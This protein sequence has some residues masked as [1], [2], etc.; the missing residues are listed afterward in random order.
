MKVFVLLL[1]AV[2]IVGCTVAGVLA[3]VIDVSGPVINT[4]SASSIKIKLDESKYDPADNSL[5]KAERVQSNDNYV[6]IP[7]W[8]LP[9]DPKVTVEGGSED[10]WLFIK[11][12][13]AED[14]DA[15]LE[16]SIASGWTPLEGKT[17]IYCRKVSSSA[18]DQSFEILEG[19]K[20]T[21]KETVS[22]ENMQALTENGKS[23]QMTF[24]AYAVQLKK[25]SG[26][27]TA[28]EAWTEAEKLG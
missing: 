2:L 3:W 28:A 12:E 9:K 17:G 1:C 19:N 10:C 6:M 13:K 26:E 23:P 15:F 18:N 11:L 8:E 21:V 27:F 5:N 7:G 20:V 4:F 16:Y 14:V 22:L 25:G 24:T